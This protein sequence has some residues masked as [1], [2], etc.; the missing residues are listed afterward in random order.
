LKIV[1]GAASKGLIPGI[2]PW[3]LREGILQGKSVQVYVLPAKS[4]L[5]DLV[6]LI[7]SHG[8]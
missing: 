3:R 1:T 6:Q 7:Q 8:A 4:Y 5:Q 2:V